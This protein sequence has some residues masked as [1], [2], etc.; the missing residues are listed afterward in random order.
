[1]HHGLIF[2]QLVRSCQVF[3]SFTLIDCFIQVFELTSAYGT[4]GLSL[5]LPN[6]SLVSFSSNNALQVFCTGQLFIFRS[7]TPSF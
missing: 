7:F 6:A 3:T 2:L 4:V 1:M 5:G